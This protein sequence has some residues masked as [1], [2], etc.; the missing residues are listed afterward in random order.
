MPG[1]QRAP[2]S[3]GH[4]E[5]TCLASHGSGAARERVRYRP[6]GPTGS[7]RSSVRLLRV[8]VVC[9]PPKLGGTDAQVR[10]VCGPSTPRRDR[11]GPSGRE[12]QD[13]GRERE[14]GLLGGQLPLNSLGER[15]QRA[16]GPLR[17][18]SGPDTPEPKEGPASGREPPGV[19]PS[20]KA[21]ASGEAVAEHRCTPGRADDHPRSG[22]DSRFGGWPRRTCPTLWLLRSWVFC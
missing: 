3:G 5:H 7:D 22:G 4:R 14:P 12:R 9:H 16:H 2:P 1:C 20:P 18:G 8:E 19:W 21:Q 13:S 11:G 17:I 15:T 10:G 6:D